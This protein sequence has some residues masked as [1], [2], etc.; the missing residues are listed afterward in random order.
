MEN[1]SK[2]LYNEI[3]EITREDLEQELAN[4]IKPDFEEIKKEI[5]DF[6]KIL[7]DNERLLLT[8]GKAGLS[9]SSIDV[10]EKFLMDKRDIIYDKFFKIQN[11]IN[12][13]AGR[14]VVMSYVAIDSKGNREIRISE[15]DISHLKMT[16]GYGWYGPYYKLSYDVKDGYKKLKSSADYDNNTLQKTAKEV[17]L[18]YVKYNHNVLWK[19]DKK[20]IGYHLN[21]KGPINEAYV[22]FFIHEAKLMNS[23][24]KDIDTFMLDKQYGAIAADATKGYMIGDVERNGVQYA[25]KG[26]FGSPQGIRDVINNFKKIIE[27]DFNES[28]LQEFIEKYTTEEYKRSENILQ[29]QIKKIVDKEVESLLEEY[30]L[31]K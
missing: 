22:N 9:K 7:E 18:R 8:T 17:D 23:L 16:T 27:K 29:P 13:Y 4:T 10:I 14:K 12:S 6:I 21:T 2:E 25:V 20:W 11:L 15:N 19:P 5:I 1:I 31:D 28:D 30:K 24:E 3:V 26:Q